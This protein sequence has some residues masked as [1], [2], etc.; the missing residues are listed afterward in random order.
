ME[1]YA[2]VGQDHCT[3][4]EE[5]R[6]ILGRLETFAAT[7]AIRMLSDQSESREQASVHGREGANVMPHLAT[8]RSL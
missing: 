2:W 6:L 8:R 3:I 5:L 4:N 7:A 1:V